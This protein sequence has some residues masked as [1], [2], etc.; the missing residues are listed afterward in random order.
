MK[1]IKIGMRDHKEFTFPEYKVL[2]ILD[3]EDQLVRVHNKKG[4]WTG[5]TINKADISWTEFDPDKTREWARSH[6]QALPESIEE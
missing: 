5:T 1:W 4:E 6:Q 2:A 3:S